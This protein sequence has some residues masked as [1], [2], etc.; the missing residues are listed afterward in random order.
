MVLVG[1]TAVA[2]HQLDVVSHHHSILGGPLYG[3]HAVGGR[4]IWNLEVLTFEFEFLRSGFAGRMKDG[5]VGGDGKDG[6]LGYRR[7]SG[8]LGKRIIK[9]LIWNPIDGNG[10]VDGASFHIGLES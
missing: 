8:I 1:D 7:K 10:G 2:G 9:T 5:G 6:D 3:G 4:V